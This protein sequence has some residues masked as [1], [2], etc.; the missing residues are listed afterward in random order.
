MPITGYIWLLISQVVRGA[1]SVAIGLLVLDAF[2]FFFQAQA[3]TWDWGLFGFLYVIF[4][5]FALPI[6]FLYEL[7]DELSFLK[8]ICLGGFA[9][10]AYP[11]MFVFVGLADDPSWAKLLEFLAILAYGFFPGVLAGACFW[12][13]GRPFAAMRRRLNGD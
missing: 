13:S 7:S 12:I 3:F 8:S 1:L 9:G 2:L 6:A 11:M 5:I 4:C 10:I